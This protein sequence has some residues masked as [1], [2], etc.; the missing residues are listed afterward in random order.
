M[1]H[2]IADRKLGLICISQYQGCADSISLYCPNTQTRSPVHG[3]VNSEIFLLISKNT[4]HP[5]ISVNHFRLVSD[6]AEVGLQLE[7]VGGWKRQLIYCGGGA[8]WC[9][10]SRRNHFPLLGLF[11]LSASRDSGE[12]KQV[13]VTLFVPVGKFVA[14]F[15]KCR[16]S[17]THSLRHHRQQAMGQ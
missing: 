2:F 4:A 9:F 16:A 10:S 12:P 13:E 14:Q 8:D 17:M 11:R 7:A 5:Q 15:K 3:S 1:S 6:G